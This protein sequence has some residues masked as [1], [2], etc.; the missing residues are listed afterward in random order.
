MKP[1]ILIGTREQL[2]EA[3]AVRLEAVAAEALAA[4]G[5]FAIALPG[6]SVATNFFPHLARARVDWTRTDFFWSDER[7]V[8]TSDPESNFGVANCLWLTPAAVPAVNVHRLHADGSP[9]S[10]GSNTDDLERAAVAD[11]EELVRRLGT[12]PRLDLLLLGVG[13]DGHVAALFPGHPVLAERHRFVAAVT[14]APKPPSARLTLTLPALAAARLVVVAA[15]GESKAAAIGAALQDETSQLP[16]ALA[17][18]GASRAW[19]LLDPGAAC[20]LPRAAAR[21]VDR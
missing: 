13:P 7:A 15:L 9:G 14:D 1:E 3:A 20:R 12:P 16:L 5:R 18:A 19:L 11:E 8:P 6:G 10:N 21:S 2:V 4:R 17:L